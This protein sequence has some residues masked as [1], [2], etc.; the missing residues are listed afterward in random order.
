MNVD[1]MIL[2]VVIFTSGAIYLTQVS[3][4]PAQKKRKHLLEKKIQTLNFIFKTGFVLSSL[5][6]LNSS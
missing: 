4:C 3:L 5:D 2:S 6:T 1:Y